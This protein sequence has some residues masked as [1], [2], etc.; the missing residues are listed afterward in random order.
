MGIDVGKFKLPCNNFDIIPYSKND[1]MNIFDTKL[2]DH[3]AKYYQQPMFIFFRKNYCMNDRFY[4]D[5]N[6]IDD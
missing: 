6:E 3:I 2:F 5:I 1:G 4:Q